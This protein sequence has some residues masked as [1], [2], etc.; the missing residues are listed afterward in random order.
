MR[1]DKPACPHD[2]DRGCGSAWASV[3]TSDAA[4][5]SRGPFVSTA[6]ARFWIDT[7]PAESFTSM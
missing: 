7:F 5:A 1:I 3:A 2:A 4:R 6:G